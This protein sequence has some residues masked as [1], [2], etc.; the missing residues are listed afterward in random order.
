M[1]EM[2]EHTASATNVAHLAD[3]IDVNTGGRAGNTSRPTS[4]PTKNIDRYPFVR[5][6]LR[7]RHTQEREYPF[8]I[9][10]EIG[11]PRR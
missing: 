2:A 9:L 1:V 7:N 3:L 5:I 4:T 8:A 6:H 10:I 11:I